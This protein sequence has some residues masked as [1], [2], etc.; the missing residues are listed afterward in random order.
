MEPTSLFSG[1]AECAPSS[2]LLWAL[3][4]T[5][6][7]S[8]HSWLRLPLITPLLG[9]VSAPY[10]WEPLQTYGDLK[11]THP[12]LLQRGFPERKSWL[13]PSQLSSQSNPFLFSS[14]IKFALSVSYSVFFTS[15]FLMCVTNGL[16]ELDT[17]P[18][19]S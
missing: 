17:R 10:S 3:P 7:L 2:P 14:L 11:P 1:K 9:A 6:S 15:S 18:D 16:M 13:C 4:F 19:F 8:S 12:R 5:F